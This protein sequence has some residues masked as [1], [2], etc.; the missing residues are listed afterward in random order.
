M[1]VIFT[2]EG[3]NLS[4]PTDPRFGRCANFVLV[5]TDSMAVQSYVNESRQA[6]GGAGIQAGQFVASLGAAAVVTGQV[7]P[8]AARV[9]KA[10]GIKIYVGSSGTVQQALDAFRAG[11]LS[12]A[13]AATVEPHSGLGTAH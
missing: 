4:S 3:P 12:E 7:G 8:N 9:L 11:K 5:D 2:A 1:K 10:A 13:S 6:M